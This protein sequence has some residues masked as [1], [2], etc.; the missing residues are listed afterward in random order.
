MSRALRGQGYA[1]WEA[2]SGQEAIQLAKAHSGNIQLLLTDVVMPGM[3]GKILAERLG[4][5]CPA[6]RIVFISGYVANAMVREAIMK[7]GSHFLQKPFGVADLTR[8]VREALD[9]PQ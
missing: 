7:R 3:S 2:A 4:E 5:F 9:K 1:V 6:A 8:K